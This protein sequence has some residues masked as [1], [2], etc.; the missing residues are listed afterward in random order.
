VLAE[1]DDAAQQNE[2]SGTVFGSSVQAGSIGEI[3]FARGSRSSIPSLAQLPTAPTCV[4]RDKELT[5]LRRMI[6][7]DIET[8]RPSLVVISGSGGVGKTTLGLY[9]LDQLR[10]VYADAQLFVDLRGFSGDGPPLS[11]D[12]ALGRCLHR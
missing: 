7:R 12:E 9:W 10:K 5:R 6:A 3:H 2:L 4:G 8:H 11:P 1:D